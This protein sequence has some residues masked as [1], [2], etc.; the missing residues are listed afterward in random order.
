MVFGWIFASHQ[1]GAAVAAFG[2]G[3][4]RDASGGYDPAFYTAGALCVA[5]A[6]MCWVVPRA[7]ARTAEPQPV[8][9]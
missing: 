2:A 1:L 9:V 8:A 6:A 7:R 4:I 3:Y 5:A